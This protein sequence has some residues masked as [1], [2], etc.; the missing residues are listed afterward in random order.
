MLAH[1]Q[2]SLPSKQQDCLRF[3]TQV[4]DSIDMLPKEPNSVLSTAD[5]SASMLQ[6]RS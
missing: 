5:H 6:S 4:V 3:I 2:Q 1:A